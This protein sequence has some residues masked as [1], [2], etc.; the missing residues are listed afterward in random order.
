M[1]NFIIKS[2]N[3]AITNG[4]STSTKLIIDKYTGTNKNLLLL[5]YGCG[6]LRNAKKLVECGFKVSLLDTKEQLKKISEED[7]SLFQDIYSNES[8]NYICNIRKYNIILC[9]F[10]LNVIEDEKERID[11]L[12]N[13]N[14]FILRDGEIFIE[15]RRETSLKSSKSMI[16]YKD[17][18]VLGKG[19]IRTFQKPFEKEDVEKLISKSNL[20]LK[21]TIVLANSI[22]VSCIK[23]V[24]NNE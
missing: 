22:I 19:T 9:S 15:V 1:N 4:Q 21:N 12:N 20:K 5:D 10:V 8:R 18:Y 16:E 3:T 2:E 17:G 7:F 23:G 24:S 6:K 14:D 11:V 13:I